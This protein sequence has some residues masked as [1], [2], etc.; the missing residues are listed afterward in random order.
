MKLQYFLNK[1]NKLNYNVYLKVAGDVASTSAADG[2]SDARH[3][4]SRKSR[5]QSADSSVE[6]STSFVREPGSIASPAMRQSGSRSRD[7]AGQRSRLV[8]PRT[9][10][11]RQQ[12]RDPPAATDGTQVNV[13]PN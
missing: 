12:A 6:L 8:P 7:G 2:R 5:P 11:Q 3:D 4:I 9:C 13:L 1:L 10:V